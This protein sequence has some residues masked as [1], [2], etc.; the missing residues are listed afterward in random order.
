MF[1]DRLGLCF[2]AHFYP[3]LFVSAVLLCG[4][5]RHYNCWNEEVEADRCEKGVSWRERGNTRPVKA[6]QGC[7]LTRGGVNG[8]FFSLGSRGE[9]RLLKCWRPQCSWCTAGLWYVCIT[10]LKL[11]FPFQAD[12]WSCVFF[13]AG[14]SLQVF[15]WS[16]MTHE[17]VLQKIKLSEEGTW[18]E[19]KACS[20][21]TCTI[22]AHFLNTLKQ[23][24]HAAKHYGRMTV[25]TGV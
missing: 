10:H 2:I 18:T 22:P 1:N 8:I 19:T 15:G 21:K 12:P 24:F 20:Y 13:M 3:L 11:S 16:H 23:D 4:F 5:A 14:T 9:M 6:A 25:C 17:Q 7:L